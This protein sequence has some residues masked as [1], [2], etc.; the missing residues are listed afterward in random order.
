[1]AIAKNKVLLIIV[2]VLLLTNIGMLLFFLNLKTPG[3][4]FVRHIKGRQGF[5]KILE[6][7]V[8]FS[9]QQLSAYQELRSQHW[10]K[11]RPLMADI[12]NAKDSFYQMLYL[13]EVPDSVLNNAAAVIG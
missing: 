9:P 5:V 10:T 6:K 8:G 4:R 3:G 2:G 12:R 13:P 11:M 1:M 7:R